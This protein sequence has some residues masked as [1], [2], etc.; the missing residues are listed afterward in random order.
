[1]KGATK[2][3]GKRIGNP[4]PPPVPWMSTFPDPSAQAKPLL[5]NRT[6]ASERDD[7]V[8]LTV[9]EPPLLVRM[10]SSGISTPIKLPDVPVKVTSVKP[11]SLAPL[12]TTP[13]APFVAVREEPVTV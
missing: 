6:A 9:K 13:Y 11:K 10:M 12:E 3:S 7:V 1:M 2:P 4:P 8:P 5:P